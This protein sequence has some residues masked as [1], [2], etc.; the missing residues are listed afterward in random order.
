MTSPGFRPTHVV[1]R[2]GM[3]AWEAP[4]PARPTT[5]LD[6]LLPVELVER[7]GDW[8]YVRCSNSWGAWVD[9][10]R[11][12]AVPEDP[13]AVEGPAG[14]GDPLPLLGRAEQDLA[15][16]R[17]AVQERAAGALDGEDFED[18]TRGLRIGIVVDG[19]SMWLYDAEEGRWVYGDGRRLTTYATD[20]EVTGDEDAG[21]APT[22]MAAP[23]G[24]R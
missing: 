15:D 7:R 8:A 2:R 5:P 1:P 12:V 13:P 17:S 9:G 16:Y 23:E 4:D 11:L 3:P 24:E 21:H 18:R 14:T 10:R 19:E 22:R 20:R 6:G